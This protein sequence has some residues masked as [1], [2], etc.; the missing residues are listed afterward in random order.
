MRI[1]LR[2]ETFLPNVDL[3]RFSTAML[4]LCAVLF[5]ASPSFAQVK[6]H[7]PDKKKTVNEL[8]W[9]TGK[10]KSKNANPSFE[11][12]WMSPRGEAMI[13]MGREMNG[14]KLDFHEYLRIEQRNDGIVYV[15]Q[16]MG[17]KETQFRLTKEN[18]NTL[19]FENPEHDFPNVIEY[20]KRDD[21]SLCVRVSGLGKK[22]NKSFQHIMYKF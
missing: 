10:W 13:G 7:A 11:E 6:L 21:G 18:K 12:H 19:V 22:K 15:A 14:A 16:P 8:S 3:F 1:N 20:Q 17:R 2:V 5:I 9:L 4:L